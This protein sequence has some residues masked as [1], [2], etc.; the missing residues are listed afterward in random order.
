MEKVKEYIDE[1]YRQGIT[2][3]E[4]AAHVG[5]SPNYFSNVFKKEF[6]N[7]FVEF[8]T[9]RRMN[10]AK[11]LIMENQYS[12]KEISYMVGYNDPNY[13]SR[14]FKRSYQM[15]PKKFQ[16]QIFKK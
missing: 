12:L 7:T 8:I 9:G 6:G 3:E 10:E 13:F 14:V 11:L 1:H 2:L 15:S 16:Q 5:L 4:M